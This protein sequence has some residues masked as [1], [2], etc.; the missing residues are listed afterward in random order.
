[1]DVKSVILN[2]MPPELKF[3][4]NKMISNKDI[5]LTYQICDAGNGIADQ[6]LI[7]NGQ[8]II[9]PQ[10]RDF[11]IQ[12]SANRDNNCSVYKSIH[13]LYPGKSYI[14]LKAYDKD[15]NIANTSNKLE[16]NTDYK[17]IEKT[18]NLNTD[19]LKKLEKN[20]KFTILE[21][22]NLY[23]L[24][25]AVSN[26][27]DSSYN[28]KYPV[29]D[30]NSVKE[31]FLKNS[32]TTFENIYTYKLENDQ[33]TKNNINDIFNEISSKLK[34]NDTFV[35][36]IAG[37]GSTIDGK[38]EFIPYKINEKISIND[39]KNN[40]S[41]IANYTNKS[42]VM[43]DTCYSGA[44]IDNLNDEATSKRFSHDNK[45]INYIVASSSSQVALE[46]YKDQGV[47]TYSV[48]DAFKNN[49]K[50]K[51][52]NLAEHV[53]KLVPQ[54]TEEKFHYRQNPQIKLNENFII[55]NN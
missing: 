6:K 30:V 19:E 49:E 50:L 9:P 47:F 39:I 10:S 40:L 15:M 55:I 51:V 13:T 38:Y 4:E 31:N 25:L 46:G 34:F 35:L 7:I 54:I 29:K 1:M 36:Y 44:L 42:L 16:V 52:S 27:E 21:K 22:S 24:S 33:V 8:A 11:S 48:L 53:L 43:L 12:K 26:Y 17:I 37:H 20:D 2:I 18:D 3:L 23:F 41:K 5:E 45:S 28:L 14:E 32:K